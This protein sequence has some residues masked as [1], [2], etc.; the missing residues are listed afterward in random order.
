MARLVT[1]LALLGLLAG[2]RAQEIA[3][4]MPDPELAGL[5][6]PAAAADEFAGRLPDPDLADA[7][8]SL[9]EPVALPAPDAAGDA[10]GDVSVSNPAISSEPERQIEGVPSDGN[11]ILVEQE[12]DLGWGNGPLEITSDFPVTVQRYY[13]GGRFLMGQQPV[14]EGYVKVLVT[15]DCDTNETDVVPEVEMTS[16]GQGKGSVSVSVAGTLDE[17]EEEMEFLEPSSY[18]AFWTW[19]NDFCGGGGVPEPVPVVPV[20]VVKDGCEIGPGVDPTDVCGEGEFCQLPPGVCDVATRRERALMP[21]PNDVWVGTC[22][23]IPEAC[24]EIYQPVCGCDGVT[25]ENDCKAAG[26]GISVAYEGECLPASGAFGCPIA[27]QCPDPNGVCMPEVQCFA[28]PCDVNPPCSDGEVCTANYCGGCHAVCTAAAVFSCEVASS[29]PEKNT[30]PPGNQ[31]IGSGSGKMYCHVE[32][33]VCTGIS[34][35]LE[36]VCAFKPEACTLEYAPVCGCDG[37]TY[38]NACAA[39]S[40]GASV[41]Y[42]G[43]CATSPAEGA[44]EVAPAYPEKNTC[45]SDRLFCQ[46]KPGAC[47]G[48]ATNL[49]EGVCRPKPE[50][51]TM[52]YAPVCGCD[53]E[54]YSNECSARSNGVSVSKAGECHATATRPTETFSP[55]MAT[56]VA[57]STASTASST[58]PQTGDPDAGATTA[59]TAASTTDG[60]STTVASTEASTTNSATTTTAASASTVT[61]STSDETTTAA[62]TAAATTTATES[63]ARSPTPA[64][65]EWWEVPGATSPNSAF[66]HP[67]SFSFLAATALLAIVLCSIVF[68]GNA[69]N[70]YWTFGK[71]AVAALAISAV[72]PKSGGSAQKTNNDRAQP[73][74]AQRHRAV[75][76]TCTFNVEILLDG[77]THPLQISAPQSRIVD[78]KVEATSQQSPDNSC[79]TE[80]VA[81]ITFPTAD[82]NTEQVPANGSVPAIPS[83]APECLRAV[84]G[85]PFIDATGSSLVAMPMVPTDGSASL[86]WSG[87]ALVET[88]S[89]IDCSAAN[90]SHFE[91]GEDWIQRALGEHASVAS[92]SAFSI[93]LMTNRAPSDLVE[94]ALKAGLDEV[95]HAKM[96]FDVASKLLG[97]KEVGPGPLPDSQHQFGQDIEALALAVAREGCL[98][99]TLSAFAAAVEVEHITEV[100]EKNLRD[101]LYSTVDPDLLALIQKELVTIALDESNHSAL[102]WRTLNW[103]CGVDSSVCDSVHSLVFGDDNVERRI[104]QRA[105]G[106]F[107]DHSSA[108]QLMRAEWNKVLD[109]HNVATSSSADH[110][111]IQSVCAMPVKVGGNYTGAELVSSVTD[112]I[113]RQLLCD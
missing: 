10:A 57:S 65:T 81:N 60:T 105:D 2:A 17:E 66:G 22:E 106:S 104:S 73:L 35:V 48:S 107:G 69:D 8:A 46:L 9:P 5:P 94:A 38:S 40:N 91:L 12:M 102:A 18:E 78:A 11:F 108:A 113:R 39:R 84:I 85:R 30:C 110:P 96:S 97:G 24:I 25:F 51:C 55:E 101:S 87:D 90:H 56:T 100:L 103:A 32:P 92:F 79:V 111:A 3:A 93:A 80:Y 26:R 61:T 109:A 63:A 54:T 70:T 112:N 64:P 88:A 14:T 47:R 6:E 98:D 21:L 31:F 95:R 67:R 53:L 58:Q 86:T 50:A 74:S 4:G 41:S 27:G 59:T 33:G 23:I 75:Q 29:T 99:E 45:G 49:L 68:P 7:F 1:P 13:D 16:T 89:P 20:P 71:F 37:V 19:F 44:C 36:G 34:G 42:N 28:N 43:E 15:S 62:T 83:Y 52:E 72:Y 82:G 77:C 76:K